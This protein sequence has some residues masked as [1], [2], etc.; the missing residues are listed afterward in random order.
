MPLIQSMPP[1]L[2]QGPQIMAT[3]KNS[4]KEHDNRETRENNANVLQKKRNEHR[5]LFSEAFSL[6]P[7]SPLELDAPQLGNSSAFDLVLP[8]AFRKGTRSCVTGILFKI[9]F[10]ITI[11]HLVS[12]HLSPIYP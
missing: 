1:L 10:V 7:L 2:Y 5:P 8:T 12:L 3:I 6:D 9:L 4:Y 11:C